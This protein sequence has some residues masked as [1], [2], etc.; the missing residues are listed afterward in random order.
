ME[1]VRPDELRSLVAAGYDFIA[2][3]EWAQGRVEEGAEAGAADG[4]ADLAFW[5]SRG[6]ART[7]SIYV[8]W[9]RGQPDPGRHAAIAEYLTAYENALGGYYHVDLYAG[10]V[11]ILAHAAGEGD[12]LRLAG[13]GGLVV[14]QR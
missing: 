5:Q 11:A 2:N 1:A 8:S 10:D 6:L 13:D 14:R 12:P 4:A 3:S 9:D 7:A